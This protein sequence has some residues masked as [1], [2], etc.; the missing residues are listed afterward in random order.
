[1][2]ERNYMESIR[3]VYRDG[4]NIF[5]HRGVNPHTGQHE[6][7]MRDSW[8]KTLRGHIKDIERE[9]SAIEEEEK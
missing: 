7:T 5:L 1:M 9:I 3:I 4:D 6:S 2:S 8:L